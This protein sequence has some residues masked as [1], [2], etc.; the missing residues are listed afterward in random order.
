MAKETHTIE[1]TLEELTRIIKGEFTL[2]G[3]LDAFYHFQEDDQ[4]TERFEF[5]FIQPERELPF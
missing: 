2:S 3:E 1:L 4:Q 5:T